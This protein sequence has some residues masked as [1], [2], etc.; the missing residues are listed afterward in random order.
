MNRN[1]TLNRFPSK[2]LLKEESKYCENILN[3]LGPD[4]IKNPYSK[5]K[6]NFSKQ[7][8]NTNSYIDAFLAKRKLAGDHA[9]SKS[10]KRTNKQKHFQYNERTIKPGNNN[11]KDRTTK[12]R[13]YSNKFFSKTINNKTEN[14][15][16]F[17]EGTLPTDYNN[18]YSKDDNKYQKLVTPALKI[19]NINTI[20]NIAENEN[21][22]KNS[23]FD[24]NKDY[25]LLKLKL[26]ENT[27]TPNGLNNNNTNRKICRIINCSINEDISSIKKDQ[28]SMIND[29]GSQIIIP[30]KL[31][32]KK[33]DS[34][35][36]N[37]LQCLSKLDQIPNSNDNRKNI[38]FENY[39]T[40]KDNNN[41]PD[42]KYEINNK[43]K[44]N[45]VDKN[46]KKKSKELL[47]FDNLQMSKEKNM[48]IC[49]ETTNRTK[50]NNN[51]TGIE[52]LRVQNFD[53]IDT[54]ISST[55][56]NNIFSYLIK[57]NEVSLVFKNTNNKKN[58]IKHPKIDQIKICNNNN[59]NLY[60]S[61]ENTNRDEKT[62]EI[63]SINNYNYTI[64]PKNKSN[65]VFND[66]K[67]ENKNLNLEKISENNMEIKYGKLANNITNKDALNNKT[68][69]SEN[70]N[71]NIAKKDNK[72]VIQVDDIFSNFLNKVHKN[73]NSINNSIRTDK[74]INDTI[75]N[76]NNNRLQQQKKEIIDNLKKQDFFNRSKKTNTLRNFVNKKNNY[77]SSRVN[78]LLEKIAKTKTQTQTS[79][80]NENNI[81]KDDFFNANNNLKTHDINLIG[82]PNEIKIFDEKKYCQK[83][84]ANKSPCVSLRDKFNRGLFNGQNKVLFNKNKNNIYIYLDKV[85]EDNIINF[86]KLN[87][88]YDQNITTRKTTNNLWNNIM[89][90]NNMGKLI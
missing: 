33:L 40:K 1:L 19:S 48:I 22:D 66:E 25:E 8:R 70:V 89:P 50:K 60:S 20:S 90:V 62:L 83:F 77:Y 78:N 85:K 56:S 84:K 69:T 10:C 68:L 73:S 43:E 30:E 6:G 74:L 7:K 55:K 38:N 47:S 23:F 82:D 59:F 15:K 13:N 49:N 41:I 29:T 58:T 14:N 32:N 21:N 9:Q 24:A 27:R 65:N 79:S 42:I 54:K 80:N 44:N 45:Q 39:L 5:I 81:D 86:H 31:S 3:T 2:F 57:Q 4:N 11:L 64:L 36:I 71:N 34:D 46:N 61:G 75:T 28:F 72:I 53:I 18:N 52:I 76:I 12:F 17:T 37:N 67:I 26:P 63:C 35:I 16:L 87:G 88:N 51:I